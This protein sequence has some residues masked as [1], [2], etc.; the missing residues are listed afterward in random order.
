MTKN[1]KKYRSLFG[2]L[3][4]LIIIWYV[5]YRSYIAYIDEHAYYKEILSSTQNRW[6]VIASIL[7]VLIF[8]VLYRFASSKT[9]LS[10]LIWWLW[11]W[12]WIFWLIH[13]HIKWD[14][15]WFWNF[16][17]IFNTILLFSLWIYLVCWFAAIGS[18]IERKIIKF[19]QVNRQ[20]ILIS[21][22]LWMCWFIVIIQLLLWIGALYGIISRILFLWLWF[23]MWYERSNLK[24]RSEII[25]W[26]LD[27]VKDWIKTR[28]IWYTLILV[29][30]ILSLSYIY[31]GIQNAFTPYSTAWDANHEYMYIPKILAENAWVYWWNTVGANMPWLWH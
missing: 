7:C 12:A 26:I 2:L 1:S 20:E 24:K 15:I 19:K 14:P 22:G 10:K 4:L 23:M 9:K 3:F 31:L 29:L 25:L 11:I 5:W 27:N 16:I 21:F 18:W 8:P 13:S 30:I 6:I 17:T 28:Q